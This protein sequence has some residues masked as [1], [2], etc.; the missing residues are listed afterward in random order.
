M[1][2]SNPT[3]SRLAVAV[4]TAPRD[5][6][7]LPIAMAKRIAE[8]VDRS[9]TDLF[10][11]M[12]YEARENTADRAKFEEMGFKVKVL[13]EPWPQVAANVNPPL[14]WVCFVALKYCL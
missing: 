9:R 13:V 6:P 8:N 5:P 12:S 1:V 4:L 14:T 11:Q 7:T 10:V 2:Q 3:P